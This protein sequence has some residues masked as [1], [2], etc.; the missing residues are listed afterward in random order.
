[1]DVPDD[2]EIVE[3][4]ASALV[5]SLRAFGYTTQGA[6]ADLIDNSVSAGAR[7][8]NIRFEWAGP[9]S[10]ITIRDDGVGMDDDQ[11]RSAM[12]AGSRN[13]LLE[14]EPRDLGR[15]GLGLKTAS[16][17]QCRLLTV[18][19]IRADCDLTVRRWDLDRIATTGRWLLLRGAAEGSV[20]LLDE[21][22]SQGVGTVVIWQQMDRVID[23]S[24][25]G[26]DRAHR[27]FLALADLVEGHLAMVFHRFL[28]RGL[29]IRIN[30]RAVR[31]WDPFLTNH[32]ATQPLPEEPLW[33]RDQRIVVR[34][35]VLPHHSRLDADE[36]RAAGGP[37]G[38]GAQQGFYVYRGNRMLVAG[39]WLGLGLQKAEQFRLA[40]LSIDL[41][42]SVDHDWDIDVR[43]SR[44]RP[45]GTLRDPL[46]RVARLTRERALE[47][48]RHRGKALSRSNSEDYVFVWRPEVLRGKIRYQINRHHPLVEQVLAG[49]AD[50]R[51]AV[52]L[53][54]LV[55]EGLPT[56]LIALDAAERP[57]QDRAPFE[58]T[59]PN[60]FRSV[61]GEVY[62]ALRAQNLSPLQAKTRLT[63]MELFREHPALIDALDDA[64][65]IGKS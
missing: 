10:Y 63:N 17:S 56:S 23:S 55:E 14:R 48:F 25:V 28:D 31:S 43:K 53:L 2:A 27:R 3:P 60:E 1:M 9:D 59:P 26:N 42:N 34:G 33:I 7:T 15:F 41:P 38:W 6:I 30:D 61:L 8:V 5:E 50:R 18:A 37:G 36:L 40:R 51:A 54:R 65:S 32:A 49:G 22:R 44:A 45:P 64:D 52:A 24:A 13:P 19:S 46:L 35:Y 29:T 39:S 12:R 16:F 21:L 47:V 58:N 62:R 20:G 57:D 4:E 11:L